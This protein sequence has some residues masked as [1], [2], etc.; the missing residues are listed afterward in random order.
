VQ[1]QPTLGPIAPRHRRPRSGSAVRIAMLSFVLRTLLSD[2]YPALRP[3]EDQR[4][5]RRVS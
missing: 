2:W 1:F 3:W 4:E 5:I